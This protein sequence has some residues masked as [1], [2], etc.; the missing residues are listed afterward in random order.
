MK[1]KAVQCSFQQVGRTEKVINNLN[2]RFSTPIKIGYLFEE[3][4]KVR[5]SVYD[6]DNATPQLTDDD[7]LGQIETTLGQVKLLYFM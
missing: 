6:I 1:Q 2:P 7:F 4:Q 5:I 3:V